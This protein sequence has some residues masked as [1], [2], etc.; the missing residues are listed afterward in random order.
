ML[1]A[2]RAIG[3]EPKR[4]A[5]VAPGSALIDKDSFEHSVL[6][7]GVGRLG[8]K[9]RNRFEQVST[10]IVFWVKVRL[11]NRSEHLIAEP[12][13]LNV[14]PFDNW[15]NQ[16]RCYVPGID[17]GWGTSAVPPL[18]RDR[19]KPGE[20]SVEFCFIPTKDLVEDIKTIRLYFDRF[21]GNDDWHFF[22]IDDP[23]SRKRN[24]VD[25]TSEPLSV[26]LE[27]SVGDEVLDRAST[28]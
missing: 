23:L 11:A 22:E 16:Y 4:T 24:V 7:Y 12:R 5:K 2:I 13:T 8:G 15:G 19:Y 3:S 25:S 14:V 1:G 9:P 28:R 20:S 27:V 17:V 21:A 6:D 26:E 10:D 18:K